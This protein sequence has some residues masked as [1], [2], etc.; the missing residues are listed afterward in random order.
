MNFDVIIVGAGHAGCEAAAAAARV[1]AKVLLV[2]Y[3]L[4]N[5]GATSCNP[6]MG[7]IG[8]T[9]I[10]NEIEACD[11]IMSEVTDYSATQKRELNESRGYAVR[12]M[13]AILDRQLYQKEMLKKMQQYSQEY[14]LTIIEGEVVDLICDSEEMESVRHTREYGDLAGNS[15]NISNNNDYDNKALEP[16][17]R[18]Q[19]IACARGGSSDGVLAVLGGN[20]IEND[21]ENRHS[22]NELS[23]QS[24]E[25]V[26]S[27][28]NIPQTSQDSTLL[29]SCNDNIKK[30]TIKGIIYKKKNSDIE[31]K[32]FS[33]TVVITTGTFLNGLIHIGHKTKPAGRIHEKASIRL[34]ETLNSLNIKLG[35]LKT[36]TP[37]RLNSKT[38]NFSILEE[39]KKLEKDLFFSSKVKTNNV[40]YVPCFVTRTNSET[41]KIINENLHLSPMYSGQIDSRGPRYC[42]S[43]EDKVVRF[44]IRD[45]HTIFLEKEGIDSDV[46]YPSGISTSLPEHVQD[47][48]IHSIKG[49]EN[50]EIMQYGYAIEYDY[51]DPKQ[52][53]QTLEMRNIENLFLAGQINGTTGY[54][55]AAGQG[56]VAGANAGLKTLNKKPFILNRN[57]SY[58]GIMIDDLI[59]LGAN[60][61]YRMFTSRAEFRLTMRN[62]NADLRLTEYANEIGLVG[63]ERY[64]IFVSRKSRLENEIER[65]KEIKLGFLELQKFNT[66]A[67]GVKKSLFELLSHQFANEEN[68]REIHPELSNIDED[69]VQTIFSEAKYAPYIKRQEAD[70]RAIQDYYDFVIPES[71]DYDNLQ[72]ISNEERE[73]LK[74]HRPY[75]IQAATRISG[76][77]PVAVMNIILHIKKKVVCQ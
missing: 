60:E 37:A 35:R 47:Q 53:K 73:K 6:S 12:A 68:V 62:D 40:Q 49:L 48:I 1:G 11:G 55:E 58:I 36:G 44:A 39:Q 42:P 50:A 66:G 63:K 32:I 65:L 56:L 14:D 24:C 76:V 18:S 67:D 34:A 51:V 23:S 7:G 9:H 28:Q 20:N 46:V 71:M 26:V 33:K 61:P 4:L 5:I 54:E 17:E 72:S 8:K 16:A 77:T 74:L 64:E 21:K 30:H 69:I 13:R 41:H 38:I 27:Y 22:N 15:D 25:D 57:N 70:V 3:D 29:Q 10:M 19:E 2:T 31:E 75:N 52:L 45:S 43:I 59:N